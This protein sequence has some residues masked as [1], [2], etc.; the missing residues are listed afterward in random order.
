MKFFPTIEFVDEMPEEKKVA[1]MGE[2]HACENGWLTGCY[3]RGDREIL[4][5]K[6]R[7]FKKTFFTTLHELSHWVI[8]LIFPTWAKNNVSKWF[9]KHFSSKDF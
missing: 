5:L 6:G 4:I 3:T 7:G 1:V 8:D 2:N 9:D